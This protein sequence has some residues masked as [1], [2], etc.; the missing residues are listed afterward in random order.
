MCSSFS[1][2]TS[3]SIDGAVMRELLLPQTFEHGLRCFCLIPGSATQQRFRNH[4]RSPRW[5][6]LGTWVVYKSLVFCWFFLFRKNRMRLWPRLRS[7]SGLRLVFEIVL[8]Y[9]VVLPVFFIPHFRFLLP[10]SRN[11][12]A[13]VFSCLLLSQN[14]HPITPCVVVGHQNRYHTIHER[15]LVDTWSIKTCSSP[16]LPVFIIPHSPSLL[17]KIPENES[18]VFSCLL[19]L[20]M[21]RPFRHVWVWSTKTATAPFINGALSVVG[22]WKPRLCRVFFFFIISHTSGV[23]RKLHSN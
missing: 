14:P 8:W 22:V 5:A 20:K 9:L 15:C 12:I 13:M 2:S 18:M 3:K 4:S 6:V 10:K 21:P 17:S 11:I 7:G 23:F 1:S 16:G 19:G